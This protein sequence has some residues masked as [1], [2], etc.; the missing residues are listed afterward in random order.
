M[1]IRKPGGRYCGD[2]TQYKNDPTLGTE[3]EKEQNKIH[4]WAAVGYNFD[5]D[6]TFYNI[7]SNR[8]GK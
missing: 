8:N 3:E 4:A 5:L 7:A 6:L 1:F 2:C